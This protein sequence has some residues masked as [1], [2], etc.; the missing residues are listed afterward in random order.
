M[1]G[2]LLKG[3]NSMNSDKKDEQELTKTLIEQEQEIKN[4]YIM[5]EPEEKKLVKE[6]DL[7]KLESNSD[8]KLANLSQEQAATV[9]DG[10]R[11]L[12]KIPGT[13]KAILRSLIKT[14]KGEPNSSH[15]EREA[16]KLIPLINDMID[17]REE[18]EIR[19]IDYAGYYTPNTLW[20]K[21]NKALR[22][23]TDHLDT[24]ELKYINWRTRV[25]V[26]RTPSSIAF[27]WKMNNTTAS[28][29]GWIAHKVEKS[30]DYKKRTLEYL[31][32]SAVG[33]DPLHI[34]GLNLSPEQIEEMKLILEGNENFLAKVVEKEIKIV[35]INPEQY[36]EMR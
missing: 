33:D 35:H 25:F 1:V 9:L 3:R 34:V 12:F 11:E 21:I 14:A 18:F 36:K 10:I 28:S 20:I 26:K 19:F 31:E 30:T 13:K 7:A 29:E 22:Y 16:M 32:K 27:I 15:E 8:S 2:N 17:S 4:N 23:I 6:S 24:P 5:S